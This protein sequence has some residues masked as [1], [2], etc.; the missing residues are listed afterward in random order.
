METRRACSYVGIERG[1]VHHASVNEARVIEE[2]PHV[3]I[4][5][6]YRRAPD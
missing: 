4:D 3:A 6:L 1:Q 2:S 5:C